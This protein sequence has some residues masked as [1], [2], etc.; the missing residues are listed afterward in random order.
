MLFLMILFFPYH[1]PDGGIG[2]PQ[3]A[4]NN[5]AGALNAQGDLVVSRLQDIPVRAGEIALHGVVMVPRL[6]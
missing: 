3:L 5:A 6:P 4:T 1:R 2:G